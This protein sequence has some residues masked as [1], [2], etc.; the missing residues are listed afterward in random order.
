MRRGD[1][2][3]RASD[4]PQTLLRAPRVVQPAQWGQR[5]RTGLGHVE[6]HPPGVV[7]TMHLDQQRQAKGKLDRFRAPAK[8]QR[9]EEAN[10]K[11]QGYDGHYRGR[12]NSPLW[13]AAASRYSLSSAACAT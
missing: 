2:E 3:G 9:R 6:T 1:G 7:W 13:K 4:V 10:E 12:A 8:Q 5:R 11:K